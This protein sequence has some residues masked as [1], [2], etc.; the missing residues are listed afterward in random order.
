[1]R[2][3]TSLSMKSLHF[4]LNEAAKCVEK[5]LTLLA[6]LSRTRTKYKMATKFG[7]IDENS[8]RRRHKLK[9]THDWCSEVGK[10]DF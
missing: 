3:V 2:E 1:M 9:R 10:V 5:S 7:L 8:N 6:F 4:D